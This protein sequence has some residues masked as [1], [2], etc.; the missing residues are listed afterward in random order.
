MDAKKIAELL[1]KKSEE[2]SGKRKSLQNTVEVVSSFVPGSGKSDI[3]SG[4]RVVL[5]LLEA[6]VREKGGHWDYTG[7]IAS[8]GSKDEDGN[9]ID[10]PC[11][12]LDQ[13]HSQPMNE[14]EVAEHKAKLTEANVSKTSKS[15]DKKNKVFLSHKN[16]ATLKVGQV[17]KFTGFKSKYSNGR[18][19]LSD[20]K[21]NYGPGMWLALEDSHMSSYTKEDG[22]SSSPIF[23]WGRIGAVNQYDP[24]IQFFY[25]ELPSF[26]RV[27]VDST[28]DYIPMA[29]PTSLTRT[30]EDSDFAIKKITE[31]GADQLVEFRGVEIPME[32]DEELQEGDIRRALR[33][34]MIAPAD[35]EKNST[36]KKDVPILGKA[37]ISGI[38]LNIGVSEDDT[39]SES[40]TFQI[41][42]YMPNGT[43]SPVT[44]AFM[45]HN[46][47]QWLY[48]AQVLLTS[49][50]SILHC[51]INK[52]KGQTLDQDVKSMNVDHGYFANLLGVIVNWD[53]TLERIGF[54][55]RMELLASLPKASYVRNE[56]TTLVDKTT[57]AIEYRNGFRYKGGMEGC[58]AYFVPCMSKIDVLEKYSLRPDKEGYFDDA[59]TKSHDPDWNAKFN[60]ADAI[61]KH[62]YAIYVTNKPH[63]V[64]VSYNPAPSQ[65]GGDAKRRRTKSESSSDEE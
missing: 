29:L 33:S 57:P 52:K 60:P 44:E 30:I 32:E 5:Y 8:L 1:R 7:I 23:A 38:L 48:M 46:V 56:N 20:G 47:E 41:N 42:S 59:I 50:S 40:F 24:K 43:S 12:G 35:T 4:K 6:K 49:S 64:P 36:R 19:R 34:A 61:V 28:N 3:T 31:Y 39:A 37:S 25:R 15:W 51:L 55:I 11:V 54:P 63:K 16:V 58:C 22:D 10:V 62:S 65:A 18:E 2:I 13:Y 14:D 17:F 26:I 27:P 21:T 53:A 9:P 45:I